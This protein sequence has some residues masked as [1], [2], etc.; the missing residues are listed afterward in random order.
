[1]DVD[2]RQVGMEGS[3][4]RVE[5]SGDGGEWKRVGVDLEWIVIVVWS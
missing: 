4:C 3:G 1:M 2:W 5:T